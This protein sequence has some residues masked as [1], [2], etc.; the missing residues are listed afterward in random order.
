MSEGLDLNLVLSGA[1]LATLASIAV[2][3]YLAN[4]GQKIT[5]QPL[6]VRGVDV[7]V[8]A[9]ICNERHLGIASDASNIFCRLSAAEQRLA[10]LEGVVEKIGQQYESIDRKLTELMK[11]WP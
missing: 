3:I 2:K 10:K 6:E 11:R 7:P 8:N 1:T 9:A 4:R 5:P